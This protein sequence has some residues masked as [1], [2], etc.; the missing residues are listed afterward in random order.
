MRERSFSWTNRSVREF[1]NDESPIDKMERTAR[2]FVLDAMERGWSGPPFDPVELGAISGILVRANAS[3]ADARVFVADEDYIIEYNPHKP[4]GRVNYSIAHEIAHTFFPDCREQVRN[5]GV[6]QLDNSN[7][8][9]EML[10]NIG[11]AEI[12]MPVGIFPEG[13]ESTTR[14]EQLLHLRQ[15]YQV[16]VEALLLRLVKLTASPV[17][18]FAALRVNHGDDSRY[19]IDYCMGSTTWGDFEKS[20]SR[21]TVVSSVLSECVAIGTT[22]KGCETWLEDYPDSI[23]EAVALPPYPGGGSLRVVGIVRPSSDMPAVRDVEYRLGDAALFVSGGRAAIVHLV[24]DRAINWGG[25]GFSRTLKQRY[26]GAFDDYRDWTTED[27]KHR[28]LGNVHV[29]ELADG[30]FVVSVIAQ[31][32]YGP[33]KKPRI[34]YA[35]LD[36][37]L[38][39]ASERLQ[40]LGVATVQMP[41]IGSGQAGGNWEVISGIVRERLVS[42]GL[43]VRIVDRS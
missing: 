21:R 8:Q 25:Y 28:K 9:L 11:A 43:N 12:L 17:A 26:P 23:V 34:R 5:R 40:D 20:V 27:P 19:R 4:R 32:G 29:A 42:S 38:A 6:A 1:A 16:S 7:W 41:R 22:A 31:A 2:A 30:K 3:I 18:C 33:A 36:A 24:N 14:I 35:A 15:K 10:C 39:A 37:G 13:V